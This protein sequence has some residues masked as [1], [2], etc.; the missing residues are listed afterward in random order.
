MIRRHALAFVTATSVLWFAD[1]ALAQSPKE[2]DFGFISTE[3][4]GNFKSAWPPMLDDMQMET[5][6]KVKRVL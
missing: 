4:S 6:L 1:A 5:G 3:S 2:I